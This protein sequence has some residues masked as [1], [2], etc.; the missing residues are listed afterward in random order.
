MFPIF[1]L[2]QTVGLTLPPASF[3]DGASAPQAAIAGYGKGQD[4]DFA[5]FFEEYLLHHEGPADTVATLTPDH[6]TSGGADSHTDEP[7]LHNRKTVGADIPAI[8][9][10]Q[11]LASDPIADNAAKQPDSTARRTPLAGHGRDPSSPVNTAFTPAFSFDDPRQKEISPAP[12]QGASTPVEQISSLPATRMGQKAADRPDGDALIAADASQGGT[13]RP[14]HAGYTDHDRPGNPAE[15]RF[16]PAWAASGNR[17]GQ[18]REPSLPPTAE[19]DDLNLRS[20]RSLPSGGAHGTATGLGAQAMSANIPTGLGTLSPAPRA[21]APER[22][23]DPVSVRIMPMTRLSASDDALPEASAGAAIRAIAEGV[24]TVVPS[25]PNPGPIGALRV[26]APHPGP[27]KAADQGGDPIEH[28]RRASSDRAQPVPPLKVSESAVAQIMTSVPQ[29]RQLDD[30]RFQARQPGSRSTSEDSVRF[31]LRQGELTTQS[32]VVDVAPA[33]QQVFETKTLLTGASHHQDPSMAELPDRVAPMIKGDPLVS[34][35][36][37]PVPLPVASQLSQAAAHA[38]VRPVEI[39]LEPR[40][41]GAI[42]ISMSFG[43][44]AVTLTIL[45]E[46]P[47]TL[48][49][50]RRH[51]DQLAVELRALG[52]DD[53]NFT[54]GQ[55]ET[56]AQRQDRQTCATEEDESLDA[57]AA[58]APIA[59]P[60]GPIHETT[61][62]IRI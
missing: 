61:L 6:D 42:R 45:A 53:V 56:S 40:E 17:S 57:V 26:N 34:D 51:A 55:K 58:A 10:E 19:N 39:V 54:V 38:V 60:A 59:K 36:P 46:R 11:A 62:D 49:L 28:L 18:F 41:L 35:H 20:M 12:E 14:D 25:L 29:T 3:P 22:V 16:E 37:R 31:M 24:A 52:Y 43:D 13:R 48:D 9:E 2:P 32:P 50:A 44:G 1:A 8:V 47:D 33:E 23:E 4:I 21:L 27:Q 15:T 5:H 7:P 30:S